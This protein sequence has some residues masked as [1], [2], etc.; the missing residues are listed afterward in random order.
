MK[1]MGILKAG[2]AFACLGMVYASENPFVIDANQ[3]DFPAPQK[4]RDKPHLSTESLQLPSNAREIKTVRVT[5]QNID[6]TLGTRELKIDKTIDWQYPI[7]IS[8][9]EAVRNITKRYFSLNGFEFYM[10]GSTLIVKSPK[11]RMLRHFLLGS[12]L[13]I[14]IDFSRDGGG[15]YDGKIGTG[16]K[17]FASVGLN[18]RTDSY[19]LS[20]TLDGLYE[21]SLKSAK[22]GT[23]TIELR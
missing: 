15:L 2:L 1:Q 21:Y 10:E 9:Q 6:G 19:R 23:H 18:S 16:E 22:D 13:T 7:K 14:V 8:Q 12:P 11:H 17:H 4:N 20:I 5:F 3:R